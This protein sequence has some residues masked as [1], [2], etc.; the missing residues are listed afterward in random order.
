MSMAFFPEGVSAVTWLGIGNVDGAVF[1][2]DGA[3]PR[4]RFALG[5]AS[6]VLGHELP[7]VTREKLE[8]RRGDFVVFTTD[9][10]ERSF[11]DSLRLGG[12]PQEV[13][14]RIADAHW[15]RT[16]DGLVLVVRYLG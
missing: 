12:P 1:G 9:G 2:G 7:T 3:D 6:G 10:I 5:L 14:D 16:D 4:P 11:V 13:A 8:L 15:R